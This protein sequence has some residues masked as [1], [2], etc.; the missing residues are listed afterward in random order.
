[1]GKDSKKAIIK[2]KKV[3]LSAEAVGK[4]IILLPNKNKIESHTKW[5]E[6]GAVLFKIIPPVS[7]RYR[8]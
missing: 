4:I 3:K 7:Q 2:P 5:C 8:W 1:M 6:K